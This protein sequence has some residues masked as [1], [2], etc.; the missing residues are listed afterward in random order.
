MSALPQQARFA[1]AFSLDLCASWSELDGMLETGRRAAAAVVIPEGLEAVAAAVCAVEGIRA[2]RIEPASETTLQKNKQ[3]EWRGEPGNGPAGWAVA[4]I[5]AGG[6][7]WGEVRLGFDVHVDR[8][9]SPL[10]FAKFIAQQIAVMLYR[11][12]VAEENRVLA[13]RIVNLDQRLKTR[14]Y[15]ERAKSIL[16]RTRGISEASARGLLVQYSRRSGKSLYEVSESVVLTGE[17]AWHTQPALRRLGVSELT[18]GNHFA[19]VS[20]GEFARCAV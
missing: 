15:V 18:G 12:E 10:R 6:R 2:I 1:A 5:R 7:Q 11:L 16:A 4:E 3:L 14:K 13:R 8:V 20:A 19:A 17:D 9:Q